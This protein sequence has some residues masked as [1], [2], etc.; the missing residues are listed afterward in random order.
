MSEERVET[1]VAHAL[2]RAVS[3]LFSTP[4]AAAQRL[5]RSAAR[6]LE[7]LQNAVL[8]RR[9]SRRLAVT[10]ASIAGDLREMN[11]ST[12]DG[13]VL[14]LTN[15]RKYMTRAHATSGDYRAL[16]EML[17]GNDA[18]RARRELG[19]TLDWAAGAR[20][21][22][23]DTASLT[24][25]ENGM[26]RLEAGAGDLRRAARLFHVLAVGT[27][28]EHERL[29]AAGADFE[30]LAA[31]VETLAAD[32]ASRSDGIAETCAGTRETINHALAA[33]SQM[34][35]RRGRDLPL[36]LRAA[37]DSLSALT[38]SQ[39]QAADFSRSLAGD[40]EAIAHDISETINAVQYQDITRQRLEHIAEALEHGVARLHSGEPSAL[41]D[42]AA[43]AQLE[44]VQLRAAASDFGTAVAR[45]EDALDSMAGRIGTMVEQAG[46][47]LAGVGP[48]GHLF[49]DLEKGLGAVTAA[50]EEYARS[51]RLLEAAE[52]SVAPAIE[53]ISGFASHIQEIGIRMQRISLNASIKAARIADAGAA[54][55]A[56]A[57]AIQRAVAN[58][59]ERTGQVLAAIDE[60]SA[61]SGRVPTGT[62]RADSGAGD[63]MR[64]ATVLG[65]RQKGVSERAVSLGGAAMALSG[66]VR[67]AA[68]LLSQARRFSGV[69]DRCADDLE[70]SAAEL[71]VDAG[72]LD[73]LRNLEDRYTMHAERAL[74]SAVMG[75]VAEALAGD[76]DMDG[77]VEFF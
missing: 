53:P 49:R 69:L 19:E 28:V 9:A 33:A 32:L 40:F 65:N 59:N 11:R 7:F 31:T 13:F 50:V 38:A 39:Q 73:R 54:M 46:Q 1:S 57:E 18:A 43:V 6:T 10:L 26:R 52:R 47:T 60:I 77:N 24:N 66:D 27:R 22:G 63:L 36:I 2:A 62:D 45:I 17:A 48:D 14:L 12:E 44:S 30:G 41:R 23:L 3:R 67:V 15:L 70:R 37:S 71:A 4:A 16:M 68:S 35:N 34:E 75:G 8:H 74:H 72:A 61:W 58:S 25:S 20:R 21:D 51:A 5:A 64:L 29:G 42:A 76:G 56:V 55:N